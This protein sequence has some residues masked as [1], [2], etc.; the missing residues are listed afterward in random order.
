[1]LKRMS[2]T[3]DD[4]PL[5]EVLYLLLEKVRATKAAL[6][7]LEANGGFRLATSYGFSRTDRVPE[8]HRRGDPLPTFVFEHR[9]PHLVNDVR[10]AGK[11]AE[12]MESASSTRI[13][14]APL[15]IDGRIVGI[16]DVRDKASREP[17][18]GD[19]AA[20]VQEV[21]RRLAGPVRQLPQ[22]RE[23]VV[24]ASESSIFEQTGAFDA[25]PR[26]A[27]QA[28]MYAYEPARPAAGGSAPPP[29]PSGPELA[30]DHLPSTTERAQR[31]VAERLTLAG[32]KGPAR[33]A[34]GLSDNVV[35]RLGLDALLQLP[36]VEAAAV[37]AFEP[38]A[39]KVFVA[40]ARPLSEDA[41]G[42]LVENLGK[43]FAR[44]QAPFAVPAVRSVEPLFRPAGEAAPLRR[45]EIAAIQSS[46]LS[47]SADEVTVFSLVFRA[48]PWAS[49][50]D[51]LKGVHA[52]VKGALSEIRAGLRYREGYR[53][54]VNKLLEPGLKRYGAL[55]AHSFNVGRMARRLA[56]AVGLPASAVEQVTVAAILH[57]VGLRELNYEELHAR[58]SLTETELKLV[59]EHPR[60]GAFLVDEV[61]WPYP[62]APLVRHHHERWDGAGYPDGLAGEQIPVGSRIIHLCE[63]FDA[64]TSSTSYRPV[65][66]PA[67]ALEILLSK[68]GTQ[69]DP[70]L[71][72]AFKRMLEGTPG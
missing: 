32:G 35:L 4:L 38:A 67:Q 53:G 63:A 37:S 16:L 46:V 70:E 61:P 43:V 58:R 48:G 41:E 40:S 36:D 6:Y 24:E 56:A 59:R 31:L 49:N 8:V 26:G 19:D 65:L 18:V 44:A 42:A 64:M 50:R 29:P 45:S 13:L 2:A 57:D 3:G 60:V 1:M 27:A 28:A 20:W 14:T 25:T 23:S 72:P 34:G 47:S 5:R 15:Y 68:A 30:Y 39:L 11:L 9:E 12:L 22:F 7:L 52:L 51:G 10:Q 62:V 69:F 54:L 33:P 66:S 21:L 55:K 17:F 71:A